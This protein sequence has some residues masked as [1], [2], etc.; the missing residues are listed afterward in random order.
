[1][2]KITK[3][4]GRK[5]SHVF[6]SSDLDWGKML[7]PFMF[8][9]FCCLF[10]EQFLVHPPQVTW[11]KNDKKKWKKWSWIESCV[12]KSDSCCRWG[13][14]WTVW[15]K[16]GFQ[17]SITFKKIYIL[18]SR[19]SI[20]RYVSCRTNQSTTKRYFFHSFLEIWNCITK[21]NRTWWM[22]NL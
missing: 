11:L 3:V 1:M 6:V 22:N 9:V 15:I 20:L 2:K 10:V 8:I 21:K 5:V 7:Y 18:K 17:Y 16:N 12:Q 14:W 13:N 4:L 19:N